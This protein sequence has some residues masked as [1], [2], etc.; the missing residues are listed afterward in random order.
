MINR[1]LIRIKV[2]QMLYAYLL[3]QSE[4]KVEQAPDTQSRDKLYAYSLYLDLLLFILRLSG[5][6][7][8]SSGDMKPIAGV[9]DNKYLQ[10]NKMVKSLALNDEIRRVILKERSSI[11]DFNSAVP[12][13]YDAIVN[14]SVYRV[15]IR[16]KNRDLKQDVDFWINI[17]NMVIAKSPEFLAAARKNPGF[18]N[19]GFQNGLRMVVATLGNYSDNR[20]MLADA[21][22]AL[23]NSL[24]KAHELY[25]SLLLLSV[26]I[27]RMQEQILDAAK[28]K[29]LP[30]QEDL[31]P[32]TRFVD[33]ALP[34]VIAESEDVEEYLKSTPVS[35]TDDMMF[36]RKM[37][38]DI[39][40]SDI[41]AQ[42]MAKPEVTFE[43][44]CEFWRSVYKNIILPNS[45]LAELLESK[46]LYWNDDIDIMGTF[47]L[48]SIKRISG[49]GAETPVRLLPMYKDDEDAR[50]GGELFMYAVEN[51]EEYRS[52]IDKFID[53]RQ[54]DPERLAFMDIVVM[55]TAIAE[56][57]HYPA[58]PIPVTLN[59]YIEIANCYS[60][61]RSGQFVNGILY[62][63]INY[64]K[65]EGKLL[66]N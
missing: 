15:Y 16:A 52:Y 43:D 27:T 17:I 8:H 53:T 5:F 37:L 40:A 36:V 3:T 38:D 55:I 24:A 63:V 51:R 30:T 56:L 1:V 59:E 33:N 46:C 60:T 6:R 65:N 18:T 11:D 4:F 25:Y 62:S 47:V 23:D 9:G 39:L 41:Y 12:A 26:E 29:F 42:Y 14:S 19:M 21:R 35:W 50:F 49:N 31:Y 45:D 64:L 20:T 13:V 66:K 61:P 48:K 54:W 58:I 2:V 28:H 57:L 22:M 34:R 44:D 32:D 10:S 7:V